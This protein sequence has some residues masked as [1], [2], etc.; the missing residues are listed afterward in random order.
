MSNS[1]V[2]VAMIAMNE[3]RAIA[4]VIAEIRQ[5]VPEAE[6]LVVDSS[7][8][9]TPELARELG[10]RVI[11]QFPPEGY[12]PAM[13]LALKSAVGAVVVTLD[14]DGTYP[15]SEIPR[16]TRLI[17]E[18]GY[19][20]VDASRID[21]RPKAMPWVNYVANAGF[22][23]MASVLFGRRITDLHSGMRAY[24][25]S[26]L[27]E[28]EF[29][30]RGPALPVELLLRPLKEGYRIRFEHVD[31][32]NRVGFSTMRPLESAWWT[33]KRMIRVRLR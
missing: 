3:E 31:Y 23:L 28:L 5:A 30:A 12:G 7:T 21:G 18:E 17:L 2:T 26:M 25:K 27:D 24:R 16:L 15:A 1:P 4:A 6:I 8:D 11:R 19:D 10:A 9:R 33:V 29:A 32:R 14:C 20:L 22:A 13:H